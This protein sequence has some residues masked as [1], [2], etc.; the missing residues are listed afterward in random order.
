MPGEWTKRMMRLGQANQK[1]R[2]TAIRELT[3][4]SAARVVEGLLSNPA[5]PP[6]RKRSHPVSLSHRMRRRRRKH[7]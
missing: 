7:V 6:K 2:D 1:A 3:P 5:T 4:E